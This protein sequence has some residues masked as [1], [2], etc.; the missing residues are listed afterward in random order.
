MEMALQLAVMLSANWTVMK[1]G[2][3]MSIRMGMGIKMNDAGMWD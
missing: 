1:D 3:V 2:G